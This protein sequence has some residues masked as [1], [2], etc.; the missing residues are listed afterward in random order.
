MKPT[1]KQLLILLLIITN[2]LVIVCSN[3]KNELEDE[4][5]KNSI[6][7]ME[8]QS[9]YIELQESTRLFNEQA[10]LIKK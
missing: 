5:Y 9:L 1:I 7:I 2:I 4:R 8:K 10:K 6:L 3:L